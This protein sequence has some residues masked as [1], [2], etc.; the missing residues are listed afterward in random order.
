MAKI[1]LDAGHGLSTP[2]K[3]TPAGEREWTL[4]NKVVRAAI[5]HLN[6]YQ[7]VETLRLDDPTGKR[8]VPLKE[9]TDKANKWKAD[10]VVSYHHNALNGGWGNH[11]GTETY[12]HPIIPD[13]TLEIANTVHNEV[14][15]AYQLRDRGVK[16]ADFHMLRETDMHAVLIE[17]G[18]MDSKI[19]IKKLRDDRVL[20]SAG[21]AVAEGFAKHFGLKKKS[22][23]KENNS[24]SGVHVVKKGD[25]LWDIAQAKN[26]TVAVLKQLNGLKSDLIH[27]GDKIK[28][29]S[30][31][32]KVKKEYY[33]IE[34]GD[35]LWD[36]EN[37]YKLLHG[38]LQKLNPDINPK[39]LRIGQRIRIK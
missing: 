24:S 32:A 6:E 4:N 15:K 2:G 16:K 22:K 11:T 19:D 17:G 29:P 5:K 28:L 9:R 34:K 8:D 20:D 33:T 3:R 38:T 21:K 27:P 18:F 23:P 39:Y 14:V 25:T 1:A 37:K 26:T 7:N 36:L 13:E 10:V 12:V 31:S 35:T 30:A